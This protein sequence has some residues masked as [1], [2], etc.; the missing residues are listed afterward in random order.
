MIERRT[1]TTTKNATHSDELW[2]FRLSVIQT[3]S[4]SRKKARRLWDEFSHDFENKATVSAD[5][6]S[7]ELESCMWDFADKEFY[8][9]AASVR[10]FINAKVQ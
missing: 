3:L 1:T 10:D 2:D 4:N 6:I 9:V 7:D 5:T 8:E